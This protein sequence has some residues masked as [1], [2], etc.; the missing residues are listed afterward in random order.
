MASAGRVVRG[1]FLCLA[2][3]VVAVF[4]GEPDASAVCVSVWLAVLYV[5]L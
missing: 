3:T 1:H 4:W 5:Q 2:T